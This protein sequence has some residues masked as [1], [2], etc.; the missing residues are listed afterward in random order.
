[1]L[2]FLR[3]HVLVLLGCSTKDRWLGG[4]VETRH[5]S[6][7]WESEGTA[8]ARRGFSCWFVASI[9]WLCLH[10]VEGAGHFSGVSFR[11]AL[12]PFYKDISCLLKALPPCTINHRFP[13]CGFCGDTNIQ[14]ILLHYR[15]L[16]AF[17][18]LHRSRLLYFLSPYLFLVPSGR[19]L[20]SHH[21]FSLR[22]CSLALGNLFFLPSF[23][24][25]FFSFYFCFLPLISLLT[26]FS[27]FLCIRTHTHTYLLC[28]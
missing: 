15:H 17:S 12:T 5:S 23:P 24:L 22:F 16:V 10:K 25:F 14:S 9:S 7:G 6:G 28:F 1:M 27:V 20:W 19:A 11:E 3:F 2:L 4:A 26:L 18:V 21:P 13:V 8:P